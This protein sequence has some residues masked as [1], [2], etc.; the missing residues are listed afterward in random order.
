MDVRV[1]FSAMVAL[2]AVCGAGSATGIGHRDIK[3]E[4]TPRVTNLHARDGQ[5][6]LAQLEAWA[7]KRRRSKQR[8]RGRR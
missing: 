3:P 2:A 7:R 6:D 5:R 8:K 1:G 4:N